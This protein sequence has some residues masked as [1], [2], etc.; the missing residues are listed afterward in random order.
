MSS[1]PPGRPT[2]LGLDIKANNGATITC[3][4]STVCRYALS[5][6]SCPVDNEQHCWRIVA[7]KTKLAVY[8]LFDHVRLNEQ[9]ADLASLAPYD[10]YRA[11]PT[12]LPMLSRWPVHD[13]V[14][15][16]RR[17]QSR[18]QGVD[19]QSGGKAVHQRRHRFQLR[20]L[21]ERSRSPTRERHCSRLS[22]SRP[23]TP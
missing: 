14:C 11:R 16:L 8:D 4:G 20:R 13:L 23:T 2:S 17:D 18:C 5:N 19:G 9:N 7:S 6:N 12:I 10:L 3:N 1:I 15:V 22:P 21:P